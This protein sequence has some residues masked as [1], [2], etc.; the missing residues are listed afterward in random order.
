MDMLDKYMYAEVFNAILKWTDGANDCKSFIE[1]Y[2]EDC[3]SIWDGYE[4][5]KS[6]IEEDGEH[7]TIDEL[8]E[9]QWCVGLYNGE[10]LM[11]G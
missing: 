5:I 4:D 6:Y 10:V 2:F 11:L 9:C 3:C 8:K 1:N 7:I